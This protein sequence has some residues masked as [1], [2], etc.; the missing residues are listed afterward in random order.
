MKPWQK[1]VVGIAVVVIPGTLI[2]G[3]LIGVY[4]LVDKARKKKKLQKESD[5]ELKN[6]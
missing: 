4:K 5:K 2:V 3:S 6:G 1:V